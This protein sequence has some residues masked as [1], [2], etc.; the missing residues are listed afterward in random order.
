MVITSRH[1]LQI[2]CLGWTQDC[3]SFVVHLLLQHHSL[4]GAATSVGRLDMSSPSV[5]EGL[6]T[7]VQQLNQSLAEHQLFSQKSVFHNPRPQGHHL[8]FQERVNPGHLHVDR[9][10][11][12]SCVTVHVISP[13]TVYPG[14]QQPW[15]FRHREKLLRDPRKSSLRANPEDLP[16]PPVGA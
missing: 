14:L 9:F 5:R 7:L 10:Q 2:S 3:R 12:V 1:M 4:H 11:D 8:S 15:N 6:Q 13:G 16:P